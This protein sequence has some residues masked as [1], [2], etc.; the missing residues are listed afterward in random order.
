[1]EALIQEARH[2]PIGP[3]GRDVDKI[4]FSFRAVALR[5]EQSLSVDLAQWILLMERREHELSP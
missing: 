4:D 2:L 5:T 3:S 1:L